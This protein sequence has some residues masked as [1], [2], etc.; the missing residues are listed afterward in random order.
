[1][2]E[3]VHEYLRRFTHQPGQVCRDRTAS[4]RIWLDLLGPFARPAGDLR[5]EK[6]TI[7]QGAADTGNQGPGA[8]GENG[9]AKY[10]GVC[11]GPARLLDLSDGPQDCRPVIP[12]L[13]ALGKQRSQDRSSN[14]SGER[15]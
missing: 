1:M 15:T 12:S 4:L 5:E 11:G 13:C 2:P 9:G 7:G 10:V 3:V 14:G 6:V 8:A